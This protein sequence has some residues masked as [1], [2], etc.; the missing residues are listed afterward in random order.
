M[1]VKTMFFC[2]FLDKLAWVVFT[3]LLWD[4]LEEEA[5]AAP[6][7]FLLQSNGLMICMDQFGESSMGSGKRSQRGWVRFC[8]ANVP[9][10]VS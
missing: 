5:H 6:T 2:F 1:S 9:L 8:F 4:L 7:Y 3:H 10:M